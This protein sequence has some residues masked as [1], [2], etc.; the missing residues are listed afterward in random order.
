MLTTRQ[1]LAIAKAASFGLRRARQV[2]GLGPELEATRSGVKWALD[3]REG[4]DLAIYLG[5]YQTVP[6]QVFEAL[7]KRGR[8]TIIDIGANVGAFT[9]P[10]AQSVGADSHVVACEATSYAFNKLKRNLSLNPALNARVTAVQAILDERSSDANNK[11]AIYSS[12]RVD[13]SS[14]REEHPV[15]GGR[16]MS[17]EGSITTSLDELIQSDQALQEK[18]S[19]LALIKLD[20]DGHE[21]PILRGARQTIGATSPTLLIEI[22]PHVQDERPEGLAGLLGEIKSLGYKLYDPV[23]RSPIG[24]SASEL[25][26]R[27]PHGASQ[28]LLGLI[29]G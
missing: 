9:L 28:D 14:A 17:T 13:G 1:K 5:Q 27:I 23:D 11:P 24:D 15:H 25:R 22:A 8:S 29:E 20:V 16:Q 3:L 21:L 7:S 19:R 26:K 4:I 2:I 18:V 10:L 6:Q 12:W